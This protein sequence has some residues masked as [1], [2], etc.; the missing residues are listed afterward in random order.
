MPQLL[1]DRADA[2]Q[3]HVGEVE[4]GLG[5]EILIPQ[6]ASANDGCAVVGQPQF[7]VHAAVL[8]GKIEQTPHGSSDHGAAPQM[9]RVEHTDMDVRVHGQGSDDF[10]LAVAGSVIEQDADTYAAIGCQQH[11]THQCPGAETV[12]HDVVL[13]IDAF[14]RIADQLGARPERFTAVGQQAKTRTPL[15]RGGLSLDRAPESRIAGGY[16]LAE[17]VGQARGGTAGE[18]QREQHDRD[19][20]GHGQGLILNLDGCGFSLGSQPVLVG[21][22]EHPAHGNQHDLFQ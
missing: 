19:E 13:Q 4:I 17:L 2:Q 10:Y 1:G 9:Q 7:V 22:S 3:V 18:Q 21:C 6:V 8:L 5:V 14:L 12:M 20:P 11:F 15:M 16:R